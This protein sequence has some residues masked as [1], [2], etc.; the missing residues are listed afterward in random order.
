M[1]GVDHGKDP[2]A[3]SAGIPRGGGG[4]GA[5]QRE[6]HPPAGRG[7]GHLGAG[8]TRL[9]KRAHSDAG[10]GQ[11]SELTTNE[12]EE[13]RRLRR[14][15]QVLQQEREILREAAAYFARETL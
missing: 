11:P 10:R 4:A 12:R 6:G 8:A 13:L 15:V 2:S 1:K 5:D 9:V 3:L 14:E 7:P